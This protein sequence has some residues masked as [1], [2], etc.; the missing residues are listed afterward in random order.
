MQIDRAAHYL[1]IFWALV[2]LSKD[3]I[4]QSI[5][6]IA[7]RLHGR[8]SHQTIIDGI[9]YLEKHAAFKAKYEKGRQRKGRRDNVFYDFKPYNIPTE[10]YKTRI[11]AS[12]KSRWKE[13]Y[14]ASELARY[15]KGYVVL[16]SK[17][18]RNIVG[19]SDALVSH[20][21]SLDENNPEKWNEDT[22]IQWFEENLDGKKI[23][24]Q[25][26]TLESFHILICHEVE[27]L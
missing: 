9:D 12:T 24:F 6:N 10:V 27:N 23:E 7:N 25:D 14:A 18:F 21:K 5:Y 11:P 13:K 17:E 19:F 1:A 16:N 26:D 2:G 15:E 3:N 20:I 22:A 8:I 4:P